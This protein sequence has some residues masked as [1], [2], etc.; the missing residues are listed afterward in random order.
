[1]PTASAAR[2]V[3]VKDD[4]SCLAMPGRHRAHLHGGTVM[5]D[6]GALRTATRTHRKWENRHSTGPIP[7]VARGVHHGSRAEAPRTR[8]L[9]PT[10]LKNVSCSSASTKRS[11]VAEP[12]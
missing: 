9:Q 7:D 11:R 12:G 6:S 2:G 10:E 5:K 8:E 1:M 4:V 3:L